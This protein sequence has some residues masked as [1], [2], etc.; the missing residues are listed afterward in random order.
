MFIILITTQHVN[1]SFLTLQ[2]DKSVLCHLLSMQFTELM[3]VTIIF[4]FLLKYKYKEKNVLYVECIWKCLTY[5][6]NKLFEMKRNL[7]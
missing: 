7:A 6:I 4:T 3:I 1:K 5:F 2:N